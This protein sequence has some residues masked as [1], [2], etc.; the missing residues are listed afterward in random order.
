MMRSK[1]V[2][3]LAGLA[4]L[5]TLTVAVAV[6]VGSTPIPLADVWRI[7]G[8]ALPG[9]GSMI[10]P[11]G[12]PSVET[13][14]RS[15]RLPRVL[16]S[17]L[18]GASLAMAGVVY[19]A[20][21]RNPLADPYILGVSS[22]AALGAVVALL[23][24]WGAAWL[25]GWNVPAFAFISAMV[26]LLAVLLLAR[27][28]SQMRPETLILSGVVVQAFFGAV[29]TFCI[30]LSEEQLQQIQSWLMGSF[31]LREWEHVAVV[32]PFLA[33]GTVVCWWFSRE[34]NLFAL[35]DRAAGHLGVSVG[36]VRGLL[37]VTASLITAAAV[38]VSGTIGFVGLVVPHMMRILCGPDHRWLIPLSLLAG[39]VFLTGAD[40]LARVVLAP[41][42]LPIGV[43][44]AFVGAPY[45]AWL[46]RN[47]LRSRR[48]EGSSC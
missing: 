14:V 31:A 38:S 24:G 10:Q 11:P 2:W 27:V 25:G 18:V 20:L 4:G 47:H 48:G 42:E 34:L 30:A 40:L 28:G 1:Q 22:G 26:A 44:T 36:M 35:G 17:V 5:L 7:L 8:R 43:V 6:S 23:T 39:G 16:L 33:I 32:L 3:W 46:L 45:F 41:R 37:L 29:L 19:Q 21:L 9:V 13:I 12:D 15:I